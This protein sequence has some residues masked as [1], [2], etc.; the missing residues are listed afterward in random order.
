M[1]CKRV[2]PRAP[3]CRGKSSKIE[4][5]L[6][7]V[8]QVF[9]EGDLPN[10]VI[11]PVLLTHFQ[12]IDT[13]SEEGTALCRLLFGNGHSDCRVLAERDITT[14]A[15]ELITKNEDAGGVGYAEKKISFNSMLPERK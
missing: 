6:K 12:R 11:L 3:C 14:R 7:S 15:R 5:C 1:I 2:L 8:R 4:D 10:G 9:P 13:A